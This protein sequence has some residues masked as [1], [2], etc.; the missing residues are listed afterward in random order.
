MAAG[1]VGGLAGL[2]LP[3]LAGL[4]VVVFMAAQIFF[5]TRTGGDDPPSRRA[6]AEE[7]ALDRMERER[8]RHPFDLK[9]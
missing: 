7:E 6:T 1:L 5:A 2:P 9:D 3:A 4:T 8:W